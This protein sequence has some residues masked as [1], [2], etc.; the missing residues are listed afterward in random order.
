MV[1]IL[2]L[3]DSQ[4]AFTMETR[5][6]VFLVSWIMACSDPLYT[7]HTRSHVNSVMKSRFDQ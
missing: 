3:Q 5:L 6:F 1:K 2:D 4:D 7:K